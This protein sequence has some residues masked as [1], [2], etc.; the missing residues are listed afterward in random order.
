LESRA[1]DKMSKVYFLKKSFLIYFYLPLLLCLIGY[2]VIFAVFYPIVSPAISSVGLMITSD[3][4][5]TPEI[6]SIFEEKNQDSLDVKTVKEKDV[7][8]PTYGTHYAQIE[9]PSMSV[10]ANLYFG[11]S[12]AV[13]KKGVG[14]YIGSS[15]PGYGRPLLIGGHNNGAFNVLQHIKTGD[16]V[17][18]TTNYGIYRYKITGTK[19]AD[20]SDKTA[21][22]LSQ[23]KEQLI[24][25]TCYPFNTLGLTTKRYFV[26]G[27][28]ISGPDIV[29]EPLE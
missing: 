21:Y 24:L 28:K 26:F 5:K 18:I 25:Y 27:D 4:S 22:N 14:Q 7:V 1:F 11:D 23:K 9:I 19:I 3:T 17:T 8:M 13:L 6:T 10:S 16:I 20:Q 2:V 15:I 12:S 29:S